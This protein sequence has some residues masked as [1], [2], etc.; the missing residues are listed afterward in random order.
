[1]PNGFCRYELRTTDVDGARAFYRD[2]FGDD[3][4]TDGIDLGPL[5]AA[6]AARGAPASW[7]GHIG[8]EDVVP[9][10]YRFLDAGATRLGAPPPNG[11]DTAGVVLR[12]PF[13]AIFA[14]TPAQA[15][16]R[17]AG[18][19]SWHRLAPRVEERAFGLY[20]DILG[21]TAL[22]RHDLGERGRHVTFAWD[23]ASRPVGSAS[24]VAR[25]PHV[26]AQWL[27]FFPTPDLERSLARVRDLGGLP[28]PPTTTAEGDRVAACDDP[29]GA[30]F[31]LCQNRLT[32]L[33][34]AVY[35][36]GDDF[37]HPITRANRTESGS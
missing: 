13:G 23:G 32:P 29:Q 35:K 14:L 30:A 37:R 12:D 31:G 6:A 15:T 10:M 2:L 26:H 27:L 4:W 28:L 25:R 1:M 5:P 19:V 17:A 36:A 33:G 8:V 11:R 24:D 20:A 9:P 16:G 34:G 22:D 7:L 18:G 21:W 3:F